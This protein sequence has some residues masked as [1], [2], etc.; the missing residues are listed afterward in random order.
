MSRSYAQIN[1]S[2]TRSKKLAKLQDHKHRWAYICA[3]LSDFCNF[4]G[5]FR[6]PQIAWADDADLSVTELRRAIDDMCDVGLIEYDED[7]ETVRIAGW[8]HKKNCPENASRMIGMVADYEG[9]EIDDDGM[10][11]NSV[12]EFVV[13]CVTRAKGWKSDSPDRHK[14]HDALGAFARQIFQEYGDDF[15]ACLWLELR[16]AGRAVKAET[17]AL[18]P[19]LDAFD[20]SVLDANSGQGAD[21]LSTP[22]GDTKTETRRDLDVNEIEKKTKTETV[23]QNLQNGEPS[24]TSSFGADA[25][26]LRMPEARSKVSPSNGPTAATKRSALAGQGGY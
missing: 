26:V 5:M 10:Y 17:I 11:L 9:F 15:L 3:H 22:C 8:F 19:P 18:C 21:T 7:E 2:L 24:Q 1:C 16:S 23:Q 12:A 13:G 4:S 20:G 6:Y 14:M 25:E